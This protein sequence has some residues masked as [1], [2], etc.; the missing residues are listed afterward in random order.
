MRTTIDRAGRIVLPKALRDQVGLT[1]GEVTVT[2]SG[3]GLLIEAAEHAALTMEDGF[4]VIADSGV[5]LT[6][7]Q[8]RE[9]RLADQR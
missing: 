6:T 7:D 1:A 2:V 3:A 8:V 5:T 9:L 4:L